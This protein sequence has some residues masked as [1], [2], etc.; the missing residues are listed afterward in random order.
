MLTGAIEP[1]TEAWNDGL[2]V[3]L[4]VAKDGRL[5]GVSKTAK[6]QRQYKRS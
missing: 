3:M 2:R 1:G 4:R 6:K 5:H